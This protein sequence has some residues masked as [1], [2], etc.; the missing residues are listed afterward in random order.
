MLLQL[1]HS[2]HI[3]IAQIVATATL[4]MLN[5]LL[6]SKHIL[7]TYALQTVIIYIYKSIFQRTTP[8]YIIRNILQNL[9][10]I[11]NN[12]IKTVGSR[13][14]ALQLLGTVFENRFNDCNSLTNEI[15]TILLKYTKSHEFWIRNIAINAMIAMVQGCGSLLIESYT[16][17]SKV[18]AKYV[19]DKSPEVRISICKLIKAVCMNSSLCPVNFIEIFIPILMKGL[20]DEVPTVQDQFARVLSYVSDSHYYSISS[21]V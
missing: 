14:I 20:E 15:F 13:E 9:I 3:P 1:S 16:E 8:G 21:K 5:D 6:T 17:I 11:C 4:S 10:T 7:L 18:S 12:R 19:N 2:D